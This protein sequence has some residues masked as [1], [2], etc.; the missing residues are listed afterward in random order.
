MPVLAY[1]LSDQ[2]TLELVST[3]RSSQAVDGTLRYVDLGASTWYRMNCSVDALND[4]DRDALIAFL[5]AN[6]TDDID[7]VIS[8]TT[9][10]GRLVPESPPRWK[11]SQGRSS[12][13]FVLQARAV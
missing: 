1:T 9:Y 13:A 12:V 10:R 5:V 3:V 8:G 7:V 11:K 4:T 2:T 6:K